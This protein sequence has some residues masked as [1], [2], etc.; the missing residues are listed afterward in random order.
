MEPTDT[1]SL[2]QN[3]GVKRYNDTMAGSVCALLYGASLSAEYWS[4]A[5][6]H[7]VYLHNRKVSQTT[8][9]TPFEGWHGYKPNLKSLH[10]FGSRVCVKRSGDRR[11]K[12][13]RHN[14]T[15]IFLG[16]TA[17]EGR[18]NPKWATYIQKR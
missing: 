12:L 8:A 11:V 18:S 17:T 5:L 1:D 14:S 15:G 3:G 6:L 7:S 16:L 10:L 4:A 2:S 13:D 9:Q